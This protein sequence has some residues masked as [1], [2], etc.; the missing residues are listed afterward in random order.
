MRLYALV[1]VVENPSNTASLQT[2]L[3]TAK[4]PK[5]GEGEFGENKESGQ[6]RD[7]MRRHVAA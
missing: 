6:V 7:M 4:Q 2:A 5:S 1:V 3:M